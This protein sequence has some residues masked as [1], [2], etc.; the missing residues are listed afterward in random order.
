MKLPEIRLLCVCFLL[1][2]NPSHILREKGTTVHGRN[3]APVDMI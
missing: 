2:R 1:F 3:P